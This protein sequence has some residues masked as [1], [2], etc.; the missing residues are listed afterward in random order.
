MTADDLQ[1][2]L[3]RDLPCGR[4][5]IFWFF[6]H[7]LTLWYHVEVMKHIDFLTL[8]LGNAARA[9]LVR[10][11]LF[12]QQESFSIEVM[13]RR[14]G[15]ARAMVGRELRHLTDM[16]LIK[17]V[18]IT[19][20]SKDSH[21]KGKKMRAW[22]LDQQFQYL[23][24]LSQFV[25]DVSPAQFDLIEST[26][27]KSGKISTIILSGTFINDPTRP[28][29]IVL[30]VDDIQKITLER[31]LRTLEQLFG[32]EIRYA[33]FPVSEFRYRLTIQDRL[34][35]DTLDF[36]HTVLMDKLRLV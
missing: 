3:H 17:E 32:R 9:R 26:L 19:E 25:H 13:T 5:R 18:A 16:H 36:P 8:F 2:E 31:S 23:T 20:K 6:T 29:D 1:I 27:R 28:V 12:N 4:T 11:F 24:P 35:R 15:I 34:L 30:A 33:A 10:I 22:M 7:L 14:A 21:K